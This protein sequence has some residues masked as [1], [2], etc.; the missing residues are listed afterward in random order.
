MLYL[1]LC[2]PLPS[3]RSTDIGPVNKKKKESSDFRVYPNMWLIFF[4]RLSVLNKISKS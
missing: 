1:E 3:D 4:D 2:V